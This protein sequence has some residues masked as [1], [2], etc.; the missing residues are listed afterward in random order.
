MMR[1]S[2]FQKFFEKVRVNQLGLNNSQGRRKLKD[3]P[4]REYVCSRTNFSFKLINATIRRGGQLKTE[5]TVLIELM[6][7]HLHQ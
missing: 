7:T 5:G 6:T 1:E 4:G 2:N 3:T